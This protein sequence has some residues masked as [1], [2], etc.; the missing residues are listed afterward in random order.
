MLLNTCLIALSGLIAAVSATVVNDTIR[1]QSYNLRYDSKS[2]TITPAKTFASLNKTVAY[3]FELDYYSTYSEQAWS[4]RRVEVAN[5]VLFNAPDVLCVQEALVRQVRDLH[6]LLDGYD[7]VGVGRDDGVQSG[8]FSAIFY[9]TES[10][11]LVSSSHL[12]LSKTPYEASKYDGAGSKRIVTIGNFT[13][14]IAGSPFTAMCTHWDDK[15]DDARQYAASM[16][17]YAGAYEAEASDGVV[18]LFGDFNSQSSGDDS[19]GY[20]IVTGESDMLSMNSTFTSDYA[21]DLSDSFAFTDLLTVTPP[22][23]RSGHHATFAGF[24][25]I[26]DSD[27]FGRIDFIMAG[28]NGG[29]SAQNYRVEENFFDNEYH[30]SDHRPVLADIVIGSYTT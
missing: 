28:N 2:N 8:E 14:T 17:R 24:Y 30:A 10:V 1:V 18:L 23:F 6:G 4:T 7:Y 27:S 29:W 19:G 21:S 5:Q 15:S 12:W 13:T 22:R 16:I 9:K 11:N 3:D 20:E 25:E 26:G